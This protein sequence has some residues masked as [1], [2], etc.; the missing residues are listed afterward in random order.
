VLV[1]SS[2]LI[3]IKAY[4]LIGGLSPDP[5][6]L[7]LVVR[8]ADKGE[9]RRLLNQPARQRGIRGKLDGGLGDAHA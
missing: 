9:G 2:L 3:I 5:P 4:C 8:H 6:P 7:G 1:P